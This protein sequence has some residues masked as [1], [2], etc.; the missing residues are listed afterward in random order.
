[1]T[2][3]LRGTVR[4]A[5]AMFAI[6]SLAACSTTMSQPSKDGMYCPCC[7]K[8]QSGVGDKDGCCCSGM[9]EGKGCCCSGMG[10][11]EGMICQ[12]KNQ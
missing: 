6:L 11:S 8:M 10:S 3:S 1:M 9:A 12:P 2:L 4:S 7:A 5:L